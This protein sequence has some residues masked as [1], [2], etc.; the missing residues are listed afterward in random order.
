MIRRAVP[1]SLSFYCLRR[2]GATLVVLLCGVGS[3][4]NAQDAIRPSLAGEAA[5]EAR[6]QSI[7]EIPYNLQAGPVKLRFSATF[8]V[9]YNDNVNLS[10]DASAILI[11]P[12]GP[13]L[14]TTEKQSDFIIRP[15]LNVN[16]L[17]P[18][19][20]LNTFKLDLGIGYSFYLEHPEYDTN[21]LLI[22]PGSQLAFDIFVGDFRINLHDRFSMEQDPVT[23]IGL[24]NVAD[25]GHFENTVGFSVLWDLNAAVATIGYDHYN[26]IATED[27]FDY[28]NRHAEMVTGS[29]AYTPTATMSV[30]VEGAFVVTDYEEDILNNATG[31]SAGLFLETQFTSYL[32]LR[33]AGGYQDID[34][35]NTGFIN[36]PNNSS[37]FYANFLLSHRVNSV[38]THSLSAGHETQLGVNSNYIRLDYIRHTANWNILYHTLLTTE[39]FYENATDSGA[40]HFAP[41]VRTFSCSILLLRN[42]S[43]VMVER[44]RLAISSRSM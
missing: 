7:D 6:R 38:L 3:V 32:K 14:A 13:F 16:A 41:Q 26:F 11:G 24:S 39:L 4:L 23:E 30:G 20:Q 42:T 34:F 9:E 15:Q 22:S 44:S 29:F 31:Y 8:G 17:W 33:I 1:E 19:T 40:A 35:D 2:I 43:I 37:D 5:A 27:I 21:A 28:L 18:I 25:Y 36:D 12:A 10:E